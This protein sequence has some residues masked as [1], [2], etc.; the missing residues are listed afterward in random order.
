MYFLQTVTHL[1]QFLMNFLL[2][3]IR[4]IFAGIVQIISEFDPDAAA[5][6]LSLS[7]AVKPLRIHAVIQ[8]LEDS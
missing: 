6:Y 2:F 4:S 5:S 3:L 1:K 7:L 8:G